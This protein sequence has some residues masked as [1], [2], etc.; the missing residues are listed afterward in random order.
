MYNGTNY[1]N[2]TISRIHQNKWSSKRYKDREEFCV[3]LVYMT[4]TCQRSTST[5]CYN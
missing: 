4:M 5:K 3:N 1:L 2:L